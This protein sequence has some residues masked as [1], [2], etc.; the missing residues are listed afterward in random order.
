M[1]RHSRRADRSRPDSVLTEQEALFAKALALEDAGRTGD[2]LAAYRQILAADPHHEDAWHNHGLLLAK[3]GRFIEA[4]QSHRD[5]LRLHPASARAAGDLADV[6]LALGRYQDAVSALESFEDDATALVRRGVALSCLRRFDEARATFRIA[7]EGNPSQVAQF[8]GG[9]APGSDLDTLL[10][11]ENIYISRRFMAQGECDWAEWDEYVATARRAAISPGVMLEPAVG[12]MTFHLPLSGAERR[13][14]GE[15]IAAPMERRLAPLPPPEPRRAGRIRVGLLSPDFR[16]HLNAYAFLPLFELCDRARL[17]VHAFSLAPDDGS[18]IR[19]RIRAAADGFHDLQAMD[20]RQAAAAI[21]ACGIDI[22]LD[23][24]GHTTGGRFGIVAQRPARVQAGYL[25]YPGSMGS[26]RV[27]FAIVD[28]VAASP[29]PE[30]SEK[31]AWLPHTYFLYDFRDPPGRAAVK[32]QEYGLPEDAFVYCAF[33][34]AEKISPDTFALWMEVLRRVP[35]SILWFRGLGETAMRNLRAAA[36]AAG[37]DAARLAFAPFEPFSGGRYLARQ[38]LGDLLLDALHH[39]AIT[40]ACDALAVGLP[41]LTLRGTTLASRAAESLVRA[42]GLPEL[43]ADDR[44][45]FVRRAVQLSGNVGAIK[46]KLE[47]N[48]R[49]APL[50]DTAARVRDLEACFEEM[51]QVSDQSLRRW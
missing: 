40:N 31:L 14:I 26:Q 28:R 2:A 46:S 47:S 12:F 33:H 17:E 30:W 10:S 34:K 20:D 15:R 4:E 22:L 7:R 32:R 21:R 39:N 35:R 13:G 8:V 25:G 42:A 41:V 3:L 23:I 36:W 18:A 48:R 49:S 1:P 9:I 16:E 5:Y 38:R 50:F 44:E 6:L 45:D 29:G 24:A 43:V 11:P 51:L 27:D 37:I 19:A